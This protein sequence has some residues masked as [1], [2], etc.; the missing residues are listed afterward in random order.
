MAPALAAS[1][2]AGAL[3]FKFGSEKISGRA[4]ENFTRL[5]SSLLAAGVPL[6][7]GSDSQVCR[8]WREELR[9]LEYGQRLSLRQR[10]VA[11]RPELGIDATAVDSRQVTLDTEHA[12]PECG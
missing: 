9:W 12:G 11:A 5:L 7:L 8:S 10:N 4:L 2:A 6:A 1:P 3:A